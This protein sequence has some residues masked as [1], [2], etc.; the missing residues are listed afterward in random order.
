[1]IK[2]ETLESGLTHTYSDAGFKIRQ[3]DTGIIYD[4]AIDAIHRE[5]EETDEPIA[6]SD[7]SD[8]EFG[9]M[10]REVL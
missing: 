7:I 6:Q 4:D 3:L 8:E 9:R 5:Y 10:V 2:I 1:M